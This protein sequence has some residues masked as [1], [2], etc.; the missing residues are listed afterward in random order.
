MGLAPNRWQA[1]IWTNVQSIHWR[2]YAA[3]WGDESNAGTPAGTVVTTC[4]YKYGAAIL[5]YDLEI[6][7][8]GVYIL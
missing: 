2:I 7:Q 3:L 4:M 1:I 6:Q 8:L 5:R